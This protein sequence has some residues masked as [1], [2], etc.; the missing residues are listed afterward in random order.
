VEALGNCPVCPLLNP[1]LVPAVRHCLVTSFVDAL[2]LR[3][4]KCFERRFPSGY[5]QV[6]ITLCDRTAGTASFLQMV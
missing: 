1:A 3:N 2:L 6:T 4:R 5:I